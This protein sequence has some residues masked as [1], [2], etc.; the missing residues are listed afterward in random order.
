MSVHRIPSTGTDLFSLL[1]DIDVKGQVVGE[2]D[3]V[4]QL[5][6]G[7]ESDLTWMCT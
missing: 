3:R 4:T 5:D 2:S 6:I 7:G 1:M